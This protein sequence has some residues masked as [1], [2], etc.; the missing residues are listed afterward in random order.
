MAAPLSEKLHA[1]CVALGDA[2][3]LLA[4]PSGSGKSDL[5][6][7][8]IDRGAM[9]VSDDYTLLYNDRGL[10]KAKAPPTIAGKIEVRG[11]GIIEMEM[12]PETPVVML[13]DLACAVERFPLT[14]QLQTISGIRIPVIALDPFEASAPIKVELAVRKH[15]AA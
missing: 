6:L 4:G 11:I 3:V 10:L 15:R 8:L 7:R 9:L 2:A 13:F 12:A 14:E 5:A 1:S